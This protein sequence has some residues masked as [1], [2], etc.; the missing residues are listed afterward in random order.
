MT[1]LRRLRPRA[2]PL[3]VLLAAALCA[4]PAAA[5]TDGSSA[6]AAEDPLAEAGRRF[7]QGVAFYNAGRYGAALAEFLR[8]YEISGEWTVLYNL[9]QVSAA[10]GRAADAYV[11]FQRYLTDGGGEVGALRRSEVRDSMAELEPRIARIA[12]EVD[13]DGVEILVDG[14]S[15][16][17]APLSEP[18]V[19]EP[20]SHVVEVRG[21]LIAGGRERREIILASGLTETVRVASATPPPPPPPPPGGGAEDDDPVWKSWWLWTIVGAVVVGGAVTAGVLLWPD[22]GPVYSEG[23]LGTLTLG[24]TW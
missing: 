10:L 17:T 9:G 8:A 1:D 23:S 20:G 3:L 19:V 18:V 15:C 24:V 14:R 4:P 21:E 12:V 13:V 6:D 2:A 7:D 11:Y 16:G 22:D 5:Q